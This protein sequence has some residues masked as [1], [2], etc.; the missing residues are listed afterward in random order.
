MASACFEA[1]SRDRE[2]GF[3]CF[4]FVLVGVPLAVRMRNSDVWT[5]FAVCFLPILAV[6]YPL[7]AF[8]V[9]QA[10]SGEL[11]PYCVWAGNVV[12]IAVGAILVRRVLRF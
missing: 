8:G 11:P 2:N 5:S 3:S 10:K 4:A 7:L 9:D 1:V 6:Y 12:L